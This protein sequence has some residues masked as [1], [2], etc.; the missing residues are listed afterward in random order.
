MNIPK[1]KLL[2]AVVD[3][4]IIYISLFLSILILNFYTR[5]NLLLGVTNN[6]ILLPFSFIISLIFIFIFQSNGLYKINIILSFTHQITLILKSIFYGSI[7]IITTAYITKINLILNSRI[8]ILSFLIISFLIISIVRLLL[9]T[10]VYKRLSL[11]KIIFR[12]AIIIG[13]G[14]AGKM[15]AAK[16]LINKIFSL[17][18]IGFL[19]DN[20]KKTEMVISNLNVLGK[21]DDITQ[22]IKK[23]RIDE[24]LIAIDN[25][26]YS[27]LLEILDIC[28]KEKVKV[29]LSSELFEIVNKKIITEKYSDIPIIN[30]SPQLN[31]RLYSYFKRVVDI[32]GSLIGLI[33]FLPLFLLLT[34][35]IKISSKGP[36]FFVDERI[37]KDCKP[38][39]FYKF[40]SMKIT[41][42]SDK[43]RKEMMVDFI[44]NNSS[45]GNKNDTKVI[46]EN[47]VTWIGK[48]IRKSSIDELPQ[49]FNVLKGDMSLVGPRPCL[50]YELENFSEWQKKRLSVLP[51]CTGVWQVSGRSEVSF[52]DSVVLDLYYINNMSP[53][54]DIQLILKTIPVMLFGRGGK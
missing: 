5:N 54:L 11:K 53:W 4:I 45:N 29:T 52:S 1:Y 47:R 6:F 35:L 22:I 51:G 8:L 14:R 40:R 13:A 15:L 43:L 32:V 34:F 36:I 20:I 50:K 19:D 28:I 42:D 33:I 23:E 18:L 41:K 7:V 26:T 21:V 30:V 16:L 9:L 10:P 38:F 25:I 39:K 2:Y 37:G 3:F 48:I 27:R 31:N 24:I 17:K 46:D 12:R 49:L 44:K